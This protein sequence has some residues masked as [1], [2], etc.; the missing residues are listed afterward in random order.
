MSA[1]PAHNT[2]GACISECG[3]YRYDLFRTWGDAPVSSRVCF[4]MLNPST[5]DA[6]DSDH[7]MTKCAGFASRWG[8]TGMCIVNLF[9]YRTRWPRE[10]KRSSNPFGDS[11]DAIVENHVLS[12][13]L[14]V[15]AWGNHG[16]HLRAGQRFLDRYSGVRSLWC[17]GVTKSGQPKHPL[18]LSYET[19]LIPY[20]PNIK[21]AGGES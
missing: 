5:A 10:L 15:C 18:M 17:L 19:P 13:R 14:V 9:G 16:T 4:V 6:V 8:H 2:K 7:T 21:P 20:E 3:R 12:S 11:N 1:A